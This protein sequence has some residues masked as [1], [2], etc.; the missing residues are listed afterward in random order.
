M[1]NEKETTASET[2]NNEEIK[3]RNEEIKKRNEEIKKRN[4]QRVDRGGLEELEGLEEE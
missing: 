4:E 1:N 2:S 3:K